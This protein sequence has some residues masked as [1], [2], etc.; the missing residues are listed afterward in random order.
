[1]KKFFV[2]ILL[3]SPVTA[4]AEGLPAALPVNQSIFQPETTRPLYNIERNS[5]TNSAIQ[6]MSAPK[7]ENGVRE[8]EDISHEKPKEK[9]LKGLFEGFTV[10]W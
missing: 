6:Q 8:K 3:I 9:G 5:S 4:L 7:E 2:F 10:E 1:M